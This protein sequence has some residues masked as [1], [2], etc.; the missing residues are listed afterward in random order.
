MLNIGL[1][2]IIS[3]FARGRLACGRPLGRP[4]ALVT[5]TRPGLPTRN[6][7]VLMTR[8]KLARWTALAMIATGF[9]A[10]GLRGQESDLRSVLLQKYNTALSA[11]SA[12]ETPEDLEAMRRNMDTDEWVSIDHWGSRSTWR[13]QMRGLEGMLAVPSDKRPLPRI[14][15]FG[16]EQRDDQAIVIAWVYRERQVSD[17]EGELGTAG[18][19]HSAISG[20]LIRDTWVNTD[21]GW[22]RTRHEKILPQATLSVDGKPLVLP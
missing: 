18:E 15:I 1:R 8:H 7:T 17:D 4:V 14:K 20:A 12:A 5:H 11:L 3:L 6:Y 16:L 19:F 10:G 13:Q 9:A 21:E 22:R 2:Q